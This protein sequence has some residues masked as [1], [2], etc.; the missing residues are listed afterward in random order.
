MKNVSFWL[1]SAA[2]EL[3]KV[4]DQQKTLNWNTFFDGLNKVGGKIISI[5]VVFIPVVG[6]YIAAAK[7]ALGIGDFIFNVSDVAEACTCLYA[8]SKSSTIIA[9]DF[10]SE[11][12]SG[13][14]YSKWTNVYKKYSDTA[15][16]YFAL[17]IM[18]KTSEKQMNEADKANSFL[19][20]WLFTEIMYKTEDIN[21]NID[22]LDA[23]KYNYTAAGAL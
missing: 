9:K 6:E 12:S 5:G 8:I 23:I 13:V 1:K 7:L 11:L 19:I 18:R 10:D 14:A 22:K 21:A 2:K 16:D 17:A 4:I 20:E 15:D 3:Y